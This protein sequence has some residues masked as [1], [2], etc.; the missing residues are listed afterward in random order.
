MAANF[1]LETGTPTGVESLTA[2]L[3]NNFSATGLLTSMKQ[4]LPVVSEID[5]LL[6]N[7]AIFGRE[8]LSSPDM[9]QSHSDYEM[10][11][12]TGEFSLDDVPHLES[13]TDPYSH[14]SA[15]DL[16][17]HESHDEANGSKKYRQPASLR[18]ANMTIGNWKLTE[19]RSCEGNGEPFTMEVKFLFG[20][21]KIKYELFQ[22]SSK[23]SLLMDYD[24]AQI[25][26]I[27]FDAKDRTLVFHLTEPPNFSSKER[28]KCNKI[29]DFTQ[30]SASRYQ[31][32]VVELAANMNYEEQFA[33]LLESDRRLQ[34]LSETS[35]PAQENTTFDNVDIEYVPT[36]VCDWDRE[37][38]AVVFCGECNANYC[39]DCD[40]VLHRHATRKSHK[41]MP[42]TSPL[43]K[44]KKT[45]KRK[46][47]DRCRCGTGATK[48]TLGDPCTGN[49][50]PCY[51]NG[52]NCSSCGCKNCSN[53]YKKKSSS[54]GMQSSVASKDI[55][56]AFVQ[57]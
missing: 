30:G 28:G 21:R 40:D 49:R 2:Y 32:H 24:F 25:A 16:S 27:K 37:N 38:S 43:S 51:S 55:P 22:Q 34:Q 42:I 12:S 19:A 52:K 56:V 23:K 33:R 47:A 18:A 5:A 7:D 29:P 50:C 45:K 46:K 6:T 44:P 17:E 31:R 11:Y 13:D 9:S 1:G 10:D 26:G 39:E 8:E 53:P 20:R 57:L 36:T 54:N 4:E 15:S 41:R 3:D 48:G 14:G 35:L